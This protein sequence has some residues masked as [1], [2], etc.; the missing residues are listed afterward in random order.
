MRTSLTRLVNDGLLTT[1]TEGRR[2]FYRVAPQALDLFRQADHRIY[3]GTADE[4]DGSWTIVVIDGTRGD[5]APPRPAPPGAGVGRTRQRGAQ[6]DGVT[7]RLRR[8][9][10]AGRGTCRRVRQRAGVALERRRGRGHAR[11]RRA[12]PSRGRARGDRRPLRAASSPA[13]SSTR[14]ATW[15]SSRP[16]WRSNCAR[17]SS[18]S[19][20][21]SRCPIRNCRRGCCRR[22]GSATAPR[23]L[24]AEIYAA[25]AASSEQFLVATADP[26]LA[27]TA[28]I[29]RSVLGTNQAS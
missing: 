17:C 14:R 8:G 6:R 2:S 19:S 1:T 5:R 18:P 23:R 29:V 4:W 9:G 12:R 10:G 3:H 22:I 16:T 11:R 24:A 13:T 28:T 27:R 25:V 26:P 20:V 15:R 7:D 21:A